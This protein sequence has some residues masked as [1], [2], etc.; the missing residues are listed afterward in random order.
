[1]K[2]HTADVIE[3]R[4]REMRND[5][6]IRKNTRV[7]TADARTERSAGFVRIRLRPEVRGE[8]AE[9]DVSNARENR[10]C[11]ANFPAPVAH[12]F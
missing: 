9:L 1:M 10:F 4:F 11:V 7:C 6:R 12:V 5:R 2:V 8:L 3:P